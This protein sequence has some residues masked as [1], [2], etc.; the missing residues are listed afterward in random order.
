MKSATG[1]IERAVSNELRVKP[2]FQDGQIV[3]L[4]LHHT[5]ARGEYER[6]R[7]LL[8]AA[9]GH[10]IVAPADWILAV[11]QQVVTTAWAVKSTEGLES[12]LLTGMQTAAAQLRPDLALL[13]LKT[14]TA[15]SLRE[16]PRT[17]PIFFADRSTSLLTVLTPEAY[18]RTRS[19]IL[20]M[21]CED[22][23]TLGP[24]QNIRLAYDRSDAS[25]QATGA[26]EPFD[27]STTRAWVESLVIIGAVVFV[28]VA[29]E[30][31]AGVFARDIA[32]RLITGVLFTRHWARVLAV[33]S[34]AGATGKAWAP[35]VATGLKYVFGSR[36]PGKTGSGT[37]TQPNSGTSKGTGSSQPRDS[38]PIRPAD[39][40]FTPKDFSGPGESGPRP[41][42]G[43][44]TS[45]SGPPRGTV[46]E[47]D[48][49]T[50]IEVNGPTSVTLTAQDGSSQTVTTD[51]AGN[52]TVTSKD[53]QGNITNVETYPAA[54]KSPDSGGGKPPA[55]EEGYPAPDD[56][57]PGGPAGL[58]IDEMPVPDGDGPM[59]PLTHGLRG[60]T[61]LLR[62]MGR[63]D[64]ILPNSRAW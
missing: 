57:D 17:R 24:G 59:G 35:I 19:Q 45:S 52:A 4:A 43:G 51:S 31:A 37:S 55:E 12:I 61:F 7:E 25:R 36:A 29:P 10:V 16:K 6:H 46:E 18:A 15:F 3:W 44:G 11:Y 47:G 39:A 21:P 38:S 22:I 48:G 40:G 49:F 62:G 53:S 2:C 8:I 41:A 30:V 63:I 42:I 50:V 20:D 33:L 58:R 32:R 28:V 34:L 60:T 1:R 14:L 9:M 26:P 13:G 5:A 64:S 23:L 56:D 54:P 27:S